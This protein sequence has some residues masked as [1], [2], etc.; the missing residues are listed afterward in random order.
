MFHTMETVTNGY[1]VDLRASAH[2]MG[3][4]SGPI[5]TFSVRLHVV[6]MGQYRV[7]RFQFVV[8]NMQLPGIEESSWP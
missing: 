6:R 3:I 1:Y 4:R 8:S 7:L 2:Q 5:Y